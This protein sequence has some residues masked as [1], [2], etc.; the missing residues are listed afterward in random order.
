MKITL[1]LP[2][3]GF[4]GG[5][6]CGIRMANEL[7]HRGHDV[8]ILYRKDTF[9]A[10]SIARYLYRKF[11]LVAQKDWVA[12]F[13]GKYASFRNLTAE[14][15]GERDAVIAVGPDCVGEIMTLPDYCGRKVFYAHGLTLR[16]PKLRQAAWEKDIPKI[17]VSNYVRQEML[18]AG[19]NSIVGVVPN[20]IDTSEY[21]PV[22]PLYGRARVGTIYGSG[23]AKDPETIISVFAEL[24]QLRPSLPLVCFGTDRR[25]KQLSQTVQYKRFPSI[26]DAR[27]LY[28]ESAV[29]FCASR[30]EGFG[31]PV[32]EAMACGCAVVSTDCGGPGDYLKS[33]VN[34]IIVK[35]ENPAKMTDEI[36]K[37]LDDKSKRAHI[38]KNALETIKTLSW[39][40]AASK[41][42]AAMEKIVSGQR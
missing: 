22:Q 11:I 12:Q 34:G 28:S 5:V 33:G 13:I 24:H 38:V 10:K 27:V 20:G 37:I 3:R 4:S 35:K 16:D 17:A 1:L 41:M 6:R 2:G 40:S 23:I 25:P 32:L 26:S 7:L 42:E 9:T 36:L 15:V 30:S 18:Q 8:Q 39:S 31:M 19:V 14:L 21:Y 29:W